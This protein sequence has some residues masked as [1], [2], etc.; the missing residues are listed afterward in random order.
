[1]YLAVTKCG[2]VT[3]EGEECGGAARRP[4]SDRAGPPS[5]GR[6]AQWAQSAEGEMRRRWSAAR[7]RTRQPSSPVHTTHD[8]REGGA[9]CNVTTSAVVYMW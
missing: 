3:E 9:A 5:P 4:G 8:S 2:G 7:P 6:P 1:M